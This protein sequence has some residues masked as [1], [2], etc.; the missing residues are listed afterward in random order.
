MTLLIGLNSVV[1]LSISDVRG[2]GLFF[3]LLRLRFKY[4]GHVII[5][6]WLCGLQNTDHVIPFWLFAPGRR[7]V[8]GKALSEEIRKGI[9]DK[10]VQNGGDHMSVSFGGSYS[11]VARKFNVSRQS[12]K[13]VWKK[14]LLTAEKLVL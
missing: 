6:L 9:V 11:D 10:I 2:Q 4:S 5:F 8:P 1:V 12:A 3:G 13:N 14:N 7:Y